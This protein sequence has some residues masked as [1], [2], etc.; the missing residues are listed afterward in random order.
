MLT[1][2]PRAVAGVAAEAAA[3]EDGHDEGRAC[4]CV[5]AA[6]VS[7]LLFV[8]LAAAT[9]NVAKACAVSGA[10]VLLLGLAGCLAPSWDGV[11][12][13]ARQQAP[14][15]PV[16]LVVHHRCAACGLPDAAIGALPMF[17]YEPPPPPPVAKGGGGDDKPRRSSSVL[18]CAVCLEDVRAG[19]VVRQL[20][21]CRH[22]FHVDCVDAWLRAHRTCPLCRCDLSPP[23]VTSKA[24]TPA[25]AA[26]AAVTVESSP[27]ALPPV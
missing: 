19:E 20:P 7:L 16:R 12:A 9:A 11:P 3:P 21:A 13:A 27:D 1:L 2:H 5:V 17:A 18:L 26:A 8:V 22:L 10:A 14:T 24:V 25:P 6:C 4:Y 23:N 15:A